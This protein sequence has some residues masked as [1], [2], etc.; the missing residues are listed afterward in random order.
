MSKHK[1]TNIVCIAVIIAVLAITIVFMYSPNFGVTV[2]HAQPTY[3]QKLFSTDKV[4]T[5]DIV[6]GESDWDNMIANATAEEYIQCS[7]II[8]GTSVKNVAIRP[9]GN[10]SLST[11]AMSDTDRYSFKIELDHYVDGKNYYGLDKLALNNIA[12]DN[13][14]LKDYVSYQM[15]NAFGADAPLSSFIY[16]TVNGKDWGLYMVAEGIEES[17][18]ERNYGSDYGQIYKP[19]SMDMNNM[20]NRGEGNGENAIPNMPD[21]FT[22]PENGEMPDM[23]QIFQNGE[24]PE[25]FPGFDGEDGEMPERPQGGQFPGR[26]GAQN[27][28]DGTTDGEDIP[29]QNGGGQGGGFGGMGGF[30]GSSATSLIYT[31]DDPDSYTAIFDNAMFP[32]NK[33]DENRLISA[34]KQLNAKENI[35]Q[36]IDVDE[37]MRYFVVHNFV[38]NSDSY[39][40]SIIHNYY[41]RE[42]DGKLSMIAW[43]YNLAFGGMGMGGMGGG[44]ATTSTIDST[45][46]LV[47]SPI[48]SPVS[49]GSESRPMIDW[50]LSDETYLAQYNELFSEFVTDYFDSGEFSKMYDNAVALISPYVQKDPTAF[51]TYDEF[52]NGQEALKEFCLLRAESV[53]GQL[54]G[55]IAATSE[56]QTV[57]TSGFVDASQVDFESM[58]S[59]SMGFGQAPNAA[60]PQDESSTDQNDSTANGGTADGNANRQQWNQGGAGMANWGGTEQTNHSENAVSQ[61][62]LLGGSV[63]LLIG[64]LLFAK[65]YRKS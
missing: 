5:I 23:S 1:Y 12:Q 37:V 17:F 60:N 38:L 61:Y 30:G 26:Q 4:H 28:D 20:G 11:I 59:N 62:S 10:S 22:M 58:G 34:L 3:V 65:K 57:S 8:D 15:M 49:G 24:M 51:C 21:G 33:A 48:D 42:D 27:G 32:T 43:D 45:T 7:V 56:G 31:D 55:T 13:T 63:V 39:T 41:L 14:Y 36:V 54:T 53:K 35:E 44:N 25:G 18:A 52:V 9:K 2:T 46:T 40:G 16:I 19:D 64:G 50:I 6:V 29:D 47:N